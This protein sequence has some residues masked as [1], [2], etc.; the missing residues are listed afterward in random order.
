VLKKDG[1]LQ[2][3]VHHPFMD[4][5]KSKAENYFEKKLLRDTWKKKEIT[6]DV[7]Y[8]RRSLEE[9]INTTIQYFSIKQ[10][11]EPKPA[12]EMKMVAPKNYH[13]LLT[14]PH[15]LIVKAKPN[16]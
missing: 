16:E 6:I 5:T 2:F 7:T 3:S 11:V 10:L 13:Y 12:N 1:I 14:N 15:F 8:Y 4:F 9:I